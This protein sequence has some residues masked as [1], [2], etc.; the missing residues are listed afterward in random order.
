MGL[1]VDW[2]ATPCRIFLLFMYVWSMCWFFLSIC[3]RFRVLTVTAGLHWE[4]S[5]ERFFLKGKSWAFFKLGEI[6]EIIIY[7]TY[8]I[9]DSEDTDTD[10]SSDD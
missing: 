3:T 2:Y 7:V 5:R 8:F 1:L 9:Y 10:C 6:S 4:K